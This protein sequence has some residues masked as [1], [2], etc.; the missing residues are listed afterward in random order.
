MNESSGLKVKIGNLVK[1][2]RIVQ[3]VRQLPELTVSMTGGPEIH[4]IYKYFISRHPRF[5][6]ISRK[7]IGVSLLEIPKDPES[8]LIG[9]DKQ[10]IR[11]NR[12]RAIKLGYTFMEFDAREH[13]ER[14]QAINLS[15]PQRQGRQMDVS[16]TDRHKLMEYVAD[17]TMYGV[18]DGN[19]LLVAYVNPIDC[20]DVVLLARILGDAD[21]LRNGVM[22]FLVSELV[23][24][25]SLRINTL[26]HEKWMMYDTMLGAKSGLRYFKERLGFRPYKVKWRWV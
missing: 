22:Y 1:I 15:S 3:E 11:T 17:K 2:V 18:F 19:G 20:G 8:Y 25:Y 7:T 26:E 6:L 21:H 23:K 5:P 10:V 24:L 9:S 12:N 4:T 13:I 16:Y 14:M